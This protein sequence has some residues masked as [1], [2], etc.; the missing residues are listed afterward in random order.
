MKYRESSLIGKS[1]EYQVLSKLLLLGYNPAITANLI[2]GKK[3]LY[4]SETSKYKSYVNF[5]DLLNR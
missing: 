3:E 1:G 4:L 2:I 5:W